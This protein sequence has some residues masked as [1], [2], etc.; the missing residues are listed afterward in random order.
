MNN[1]KIKS[2]ITF[3][4]FLIINF[5]ALALGALFTGEGVPSAWYQNINKAPWT[6]PGWVFGFAWTT[7][8][9]CFS[10]Y[11][12]YLWNITA[13]KKPLIILFTLQWVLNFSW[14]PLFFFHH[15]VGVALFTIFALTI[16]VGYFLFSNWKQLQLKSLLIAPY[17]VWLLIATS[18]NAY[19]YW[20]N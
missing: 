10:F 3:L 5:A 18:L 17:F 12:T 11:M 1:P 15:A 16:L 14:N 19:I 13:N 9:I 4:I 20:Y 2:I 7:I 8:M 6:P